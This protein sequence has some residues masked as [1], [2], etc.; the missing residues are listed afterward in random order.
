MPLHYLVPHTTLKAIALDSIL[1]AIMAVIKRAPTNKKLPVSATARIHPAL[2]TMVFG[3]MEPFILRSKEEI[4]K[5]FGIDRKY[6]KRGSYAV[7]IP[8]LEVGYHTNSHTTTIKINYQVFSQADVLQWPV[9]H[10]VDLYV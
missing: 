1:P 10:E 8:P 7:V 3:T 9:V 2:Q 5:M 4:V 6:F